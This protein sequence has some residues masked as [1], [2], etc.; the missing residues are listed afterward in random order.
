MAIQING[1]AACS[2]LAVTVYSVVMEP[3][4]CRILGHQF[5][6]AQL[7]CRALTHR[8][9]V[10][11]Q[12]C[13]GLEDYQRLEFLGDAVLGLLLADLLYRRFPHLA[14]GHLSRM[15]ASLVE[16]RRLAVLADA[17]GLPGLIMLGRGAEQEGGRS[18]PGILADVFEAVVGAIYCDGGY[19]AVCRVIDALYAPLLQELEQMQAACT[20]AKSTLQERLAAAQLSPPVYRVS[21]QRGA[22]HDRWFEVQVVVD[23][24]VVGKGG[25]RSKKAAQQAAA[26]AALER[27]LTRRA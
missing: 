17:A 2:L 6:D 20:D 23:D 19:E 25:G 1:F 27:L 24:E 8:S 11:E 12:R 15:R 4:P 21:D 13:S 18:N 5:S 9:Y 16:Q 22:D 3:Q 10:N 14:E 7:A 26:A